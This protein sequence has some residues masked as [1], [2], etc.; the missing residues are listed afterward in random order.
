MK[1]SGNMW[2]MILS[3]VT[4]NQ[5]FTLP[6]EDTFFKK[7][8]GRGESNWPPSRSRVKILAKVNLF[9]YDVFVW[10]IIKLLDYMKD[11]LGIFLVMKRRIL[12]IC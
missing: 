1:F 3:K 7:P 4:K 2:L 10:W 9:G 5:G 8:Q 11:A 6:L 12:W